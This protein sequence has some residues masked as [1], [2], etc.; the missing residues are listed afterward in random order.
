MNLFYLVPSDL[1]DTF[2]DEEESY[3]CIKVLRRK[4]SD[5]IYLIDGKGGYY[6]AI[7]TQANYKKCA[8]LI[9]RKIQQ[10]LPLHDIHIVISPPKSLDRLEFFVEKATEMGVDKISFINSNRT[11]RKGINK[12]RLEKIICS[13]AK[14]SRR[15]FFPVLSAFIS[16][17]NFLSQRINA[18]KYIAHCSPNIS[19][20]FLGK[21]ISKSE[22]IVILI[23][24]EGDFT[25]EEIAQALAL[26]YQSISLGNQRLR[27]ETAGLVALNICQFARRMG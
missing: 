14:Q 6:E 20:I 19:K 18:Q 9:Q 7:I 26:Q 25:T 8:I 23:G 3:H 15:T 27:T 13:A 11:E 17:E 5:T 4:E 10:T 1:Q 12:E 24:P 22:N 2:L 21:C 16:Y